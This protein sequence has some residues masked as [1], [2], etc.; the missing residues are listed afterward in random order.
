MTNIYYD[1]ALSDDARR[2]QLY[3]GDIFVYSPTAAT[4]ALVQ[5]ARDMVE[6]A[7]APHDP[8]KVQDALPVDHCVEVL[9]RVKPQF[10]HHPRCKELIPAALAELGCDL[11]KTYFDVPRLRS[12]MPQDYLTSGIAYAFHPHRDT[13]YSAPFFQINWWL[14]VYDLSPQNCLAFHPHYFSKAVKN[15]SAGYNYYRWNA[16]NRGSASQH[17][18][19]DTRAQPKAE[20]PMELDPQ[21]RIIVPPG[22]AILFCGAQMHSTVPNTSGV[23]RYSIDFRTVHL[24]DAVHRR[25]AANV[26]TAATGTTMRDYLRATDLSHIPDRVIH[27]YD[28]GT[29]GEGLLVY[30]PTESAPRTPVTH[31]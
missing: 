20:E 8:R 1:S 19:S 14:P 27:M 12:A 16:E 7:F 26:D 6:T 31:G 2:E 4:R 21:L 24:D 13:W 17:V 11:E 18:K 22:S 10:I 9:A 30:P 15:G 3:L 25:G 23:C 28:D 29:E 5:H